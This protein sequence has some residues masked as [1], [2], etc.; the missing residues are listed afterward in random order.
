MPTFR[1]PPEVTLKVLSRISRSSPA[2]LIGLEHRKTVQPMS[3][4]GA[5]TWHAN[6]RK[7]PEERK[8]F[9][10]KSRQICGRNAQISVQAC[11]IDPEAQSPDELRPDPKS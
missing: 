9:H 7:F 11:Q 8:P 3:T 5:A 4:A 2:C 1:V 10:G 6:V